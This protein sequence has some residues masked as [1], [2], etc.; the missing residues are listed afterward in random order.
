[1]SVYT[2]TNRDNQEVIHVLYIVNLSQTFI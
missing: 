1:M 2:N